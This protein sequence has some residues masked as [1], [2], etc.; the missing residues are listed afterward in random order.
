MQCKNNYL[1]IIEWNR[2]QID[3]KSDTTKLCKSSY[4]FYSKKF[5]MSNVLLL[6]RSER[7]KSAKII[8]IY[9]IC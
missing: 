4:H 8:M 3:K 1:S 6:V 7:K 9:L 5:T 2:L